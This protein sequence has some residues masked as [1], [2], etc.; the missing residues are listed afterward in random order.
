MNQINVKAVLILN[1]L[2][3]CLK[4]AADCRQVV[5]FVENLKGEAEAFALKS[6]GVYSGDH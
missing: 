5:V 3:C 1:L 2:L 4:I 6:M